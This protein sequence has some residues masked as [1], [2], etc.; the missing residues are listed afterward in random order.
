[1][2]QVGDRGAF[3]WQGLRLA[4]TAAAAAKARVEGSVTEQV[5]ALLSVDKVQGFKLQVAASSVIGAGLGVHVRR[6]A[7]EHGGDQ[8]P[9]GAVVTL[10]PG[11][12]FPSVPR[13][14]H[15]WDEVVVDAIRLMQMHGGGCVDPKLDGASFQE[16]SSYMLV[17]T[18]GVG[19]IM[20][21][22]RATERV[23]GLVDRGQQAVGNLI[24]HPPQGTSPNVAWCEFPWAKTSCEASGINRMHQ[25]VWYVDPPT[26]E[27]VLVPDPGAVDA[28]AEP[29]VAIVALRAID[30]GEE[31]FMDYKLAKP[32]PEWYVPALAV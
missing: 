30:G 5:R 6:G 31:L 15:L 24:N 22:F 2:G 18:S 32:H 4:A 10:Y 8:I 25:G 11:V 13:H 1:M 3:R 14:V 29:G 19:G 23:P 27:P 9:C 21:G 26:L 20:D 28:L 12:F 16:I 7:G 17:L